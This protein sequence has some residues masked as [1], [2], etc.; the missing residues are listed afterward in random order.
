VRY[1]ARPRTF[2]LAFGVALTLVLTSCSNTAPEAST[3]TSTSEA[4]AIQ[5]AVFGDSLAWE[6]QPYYDDLARAAGD[7]AHTYDS[8]GGSAICDWLTQM[9]RVQAKYHPMAVQLE[10]SGNNLTPCMKGY[11]LYS[12]EYYEKYR[13]DTLNAI[14]IFTAGGAHVFLIGAPITRAQQ[15]V[16][17]WQ[18]LN[19]Q[20]EEIAAADPAHV[21]YV[22]AGATVELPGQRYTDTLPCLERESCT[23]PVVD[24]IRSNVV[25]SSDGVHFCPTEKGLDSGV[26][27]GCSVYSSGAY[28]YAKAM[29]DALEA[30]SSRE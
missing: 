7:V 15:S 19:M 16:P 28:R 10:F 17:D 18:R 14:R 6:A 8:H 3:E 1:R 24:A 30:K 27:G 23:G 20:Y 26:I 9:R 12:P 25:R 2:G 4:T 21:T 29:F 11:E 5:I 13:A 22:D